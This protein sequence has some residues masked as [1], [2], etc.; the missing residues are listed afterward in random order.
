MSNR[1]RKTDEL[2]L[3]KDEEA[4][5]QDREGL[6]SPVIFE[7]IRREGEAELERPV[8]SLGLSGVA[9]GLA[10]GFSVVGEAVLHAYLPEAPW[11][12]LVESF[13]YTLGFLMVILGR[14]QLFTE[15]TI[16]PVLPVLLNPSRSAVMRTAR[17]WGIV[18]AA[19]IVGC[20]AF[21]AAISVPGVVPIEVYNAAMSISHHM[22]E[23]TI[24]E[25]FVRGIFSGWLIASLVW[26]MPSA[27]TAKFW[28]IIL[29]TYVIAA[30]SFT[31]VVAGSIE[32]FLLV[33]NGELTLW[34]MAVDFFIPV[35]AGNVIGGS[36]L[37]A[38]L[39]YG[40]VSQE[41]EG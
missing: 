4:E 11:R 33:L 40:Q 8:F 34:A 26:M 9:A 21:A 39:S 29:V 7:I 10:I 28:A 37:F 12:H 19:N 32:A 6:R 15:N 36:V 41:V 14:L 20:L 22:M 16:T 3:S 25:M 5:V 13:G 31:H 38:L 35:L 24:W 18:L 2:E 1:S 23:N 27:E 17:L 30:G